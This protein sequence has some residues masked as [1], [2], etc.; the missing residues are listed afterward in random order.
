MRL[1]ERPTLHSFIAGLSALDT[2]VMCSKILGG[3]LLLVA[4]ASALPGAQIV[5]KRTVDDQVP[6]FEDG[7]PIGHGKGAPLVGEFIWHLG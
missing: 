6:Q 4:G 7:Q 1:L 2:M 5:N 3:L